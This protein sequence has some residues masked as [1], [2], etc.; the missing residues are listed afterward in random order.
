MNRRPVPRGGRHPG[1]G[2]GN[3]T[4][5]VAGDA[6]VRGSDGFIYYA[7][8]DCDRGSRAAV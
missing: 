2:R 7:H 1:V 5:Y 8:W 3:E 6:V 4:E